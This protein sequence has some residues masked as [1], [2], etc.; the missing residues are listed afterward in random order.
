MQNG[1]LK[2][3]YNPRSLSETRYKIAIIEMGV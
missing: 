2:V 1:K 3:W